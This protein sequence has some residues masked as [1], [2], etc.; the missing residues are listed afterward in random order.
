MD[1]LR[2]GFL[3]GEILGQGRQDSQTPPHS[4]GGFSQAFQHR[5][6]LGV[7]LANTSPLRWGFLGP[8]YGLAGDGLANTSP[9]RWGFL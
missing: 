4:G 2:W 1:P 8:A 9:L 7:N 5:A 3:K 6:M